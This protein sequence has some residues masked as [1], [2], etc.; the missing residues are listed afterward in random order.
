L[1]AAK[2]IV[3]DGVAF[4]KGGALEFSRANLGDVMGQ[5]GAHRIL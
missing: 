2:I 4:V 3:A 5:F 1:K